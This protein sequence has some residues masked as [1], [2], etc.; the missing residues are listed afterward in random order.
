[1]F[2]KRMST[3]Y[4]GFLVH[5]GD[6]WRRRTEIVERL[7]GFNTPECAH[8]LFS[9]LERV[10]SNSSTRRYLASVLKVLA[11]MP[12]EL[13]QSRLLEPIADNRFSPRM[14]NRF[15]EALDRASRR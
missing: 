6:D 4:I 12:R 8:F 7:E 14:R 3:N 2:Q 13:V 11:A 9:E 10:K 15:I 5:A 1:M